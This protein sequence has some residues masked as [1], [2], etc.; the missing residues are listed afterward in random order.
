V[1]DVS[2]SGKERIYIYTALLDIL[3]QGAEPIAL[4]SLR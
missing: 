4:S 3:E 1:K 2:G